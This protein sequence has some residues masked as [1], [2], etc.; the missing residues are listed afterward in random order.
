MS[1]PSKKDV[2][3]LVNRYRLKEAKELFKNIGEDLDDFIA[4]PKRSRTAN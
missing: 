4:C 2:T 3:Y 1:L